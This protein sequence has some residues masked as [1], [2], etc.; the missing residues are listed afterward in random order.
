[1]YIEFIQNV[2]YKFSKRDK[3]MTFGHLGVMPYPAC[4]FVVLSHV[5]AADNPFTPFSR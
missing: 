5:H 3:I 4:K 1:M 2:E